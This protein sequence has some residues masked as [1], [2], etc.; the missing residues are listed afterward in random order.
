M[1]DYNANVIAREEISPGNIVVRIKADADLFEFEPGQFAVLGL[2][3][4]APRADYAGPDPE[5]DPVRK[6]DKPIRRA[7]S[8]ASSS[9][10][11]QAAQEWFVAR[12][13]RPDEHGNPGNVHTEK[14][15]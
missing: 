12:G 15:W 11:R 3:S 13:F 1:M 9:R 8:I 14:Y 6:P 4:D 10:E 5:D 7:Y 2:R